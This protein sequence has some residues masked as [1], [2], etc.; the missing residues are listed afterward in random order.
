MAR[1]ALIGTG[2]VSRAL[3]GSLANAGH[4]IRFGSRHPNEVSV[5]PGTHAVGLKDAV[6][7][8]EYAILAV[9]Y[10]AVPETM[11]VIGPTLKGKLLI[12]ATNA[13]N[14]DSELALG[15][16][17]S[18]AEEIA[19]LAPDAHVVKAFNTVFRQNMPTGHVGEDPLTLFV[20]GDNPEAKERVIELGR[21][22]G[23]EPVDV[24]PLRHARYLEPMAVLL[25]RM[26]HR[27]NLGTD[28]GFRLIR[29]S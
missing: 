19:K 12:D 28:M 6:E 4:E 1:I 27:M 25:I 13:M 9:P 26:G 17:T 21:Q 23:F 3:A 8:S 14:P 24:G 16:T 2:K 22:L 10:A 18:G 5:P 7:W 29:G 20:A 11:K 15:L